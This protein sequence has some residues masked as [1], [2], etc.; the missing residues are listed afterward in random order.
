MDFWICS[1]FLLK[2]RKSDHKNKACVDSQSQF[3]SNCQLNLSPT[4]VWLDLIDVVLLKDFLK[5]KS[6]GGKGFPTGCNN[7]YPILQ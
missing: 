5:E 1:A 3:V 7:S 4:F 2:H 6:E